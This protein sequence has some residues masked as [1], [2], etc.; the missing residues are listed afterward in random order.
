MPGQAEIMLE[1]GEYKPRPKE[2]LFDAGVPGGAAPAGGE[3][4]ER[5]E[6]HYG[7]TPQTETRLR[8]GKPKDIFLHPG[9]HKRR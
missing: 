9:C 6:V 2:A 7:T 1:R 5:S 4:Y 3:L 8:N